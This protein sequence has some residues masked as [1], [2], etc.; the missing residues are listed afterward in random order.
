MKHSMISFN[1]QITMRIVIALW[2][3]LLCPNALASDKVPVIV[4]ERAFEIKAEDSDSVRM[5]K[6]KLVFSRFATSGNNKE[7]VVRDPFTGSEKVIVSGQKDAWFIAEDDRYIAY[8]DYFLS[9]AASPLILVNKAS[10]KNVGSIKIRDGAY[11]GFLKNNQLFAFHG[12]LPPN[13]HNK[14]SRVSV[15]EVP[16]LKFNRSFE[17]V[18]NG[19]FFLWQD[20]IVSLGSSD[21]VI[22]DAMFNQKLSA[23]IPY[24]PVGNAYCG[25]SSLINV[26]DT[27]IFIAQCGTIY[28][29]SLVRGVLEEKIKFPGKFYDLVP[30]G[31]LLF[32]IPKL[33]SDV[34]NSCSAAI[35]DLKRW[36]I[37]ERFKT[38][39]SIS[40]YANNGKLVIVSRLSWDKALVSIYTYSMPKHS[41]KYEGGP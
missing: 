10:R 4:L 23:S 33:E 1:K 15:F 28:S 12:I 17:I 29:F 11:V 26:N 32:V 13:P 27:A 21:I 38:K 8:Y 3:M 25:S 35:I 2:G 24:T 31:D 34:N 6:G 20:G 22:Y 18:G 9:R 41:K 16:S 36:E 14:T 40:A 7:I 37:I 5:S 19:H 30:D 39:A